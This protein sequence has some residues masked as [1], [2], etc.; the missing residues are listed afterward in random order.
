MIEPAPHFD[1]HQEDDQVATRRVVHV[2]LVGV[3]T[4]AVGVFCA[5]V[6]LVA[7]TGALR[8]K[9]AGPDGTRPS[10]AQI[11]KVEQTPIRDT[12]RGLDLREAQRSELE[13][14]SWI[15]RSAGVATI[16]IDT[17]IDIVVERGQ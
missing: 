12:R 10:T 6:I 13:R 3:L 8:P 7:S 17:A 14:W 16:P 11:S 2:A 15:D 1:V 9:L 5:G 4:G